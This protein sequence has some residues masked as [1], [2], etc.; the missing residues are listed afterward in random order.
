MS[1]WC[2]IDQARLYWADAPEDDALL[3]EYLDGA[4]EGCEAYAPALPAP[5]PP[6]PLEVPARYTQ[7]VALLAQ[8]HLNAFMR[9]TG[10]VIGFGDT[11]WP[12][13]AKPLPASVKALLRPRR[14]VP[15]VG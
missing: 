12:I 10:D 9:D 8:E 5:I 14:A 1:A 4:Q 11:G 2:S 7:A 15:R 3:E 6:D 13:R